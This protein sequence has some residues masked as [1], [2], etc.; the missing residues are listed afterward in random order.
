[1]SKDSHRDAPAVVHLGTQFLE[2]VGAH[3]VELQHVRIL[4]GI[5][6]LTNRIHDAVL[7]FLSLGLGLRQTHYNRHLFGRLDLPTWFL[8]DLGIFYW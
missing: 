3:V 5:D 7:Q 4:V 2:S 8:F 6:G 1:M